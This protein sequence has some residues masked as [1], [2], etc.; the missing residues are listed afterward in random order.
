MSV[1]AVVVYICVWVCVR[2]VGREVLGNSMARDV[3]GIS[4]EISGSLGKSQ[5][6]LGNMARDVLGNRN[7]GAES[8]I[9]MSDTSRHAASQRL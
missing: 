3:L 7:K 2:V 9:L 5:E 8:L 4:R 1:E 6:Q